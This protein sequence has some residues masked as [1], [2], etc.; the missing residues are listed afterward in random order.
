MRV[1]NHMHF[2]FLSGFS[3]FDEIDVIHE[4]SFNTDAIEVSQLSLEMVVLVAYQGLGL[5]ELF[6]LIVIGRHVPLVDDLGR[7]DTLMGDQCLQHQY[8]E[9]ETDAKVSIFGQGR[10]RKWIH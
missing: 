3:S 9:E 6:F 10:K 2:P 7:N 1:D 8:Y 5:L 4:E